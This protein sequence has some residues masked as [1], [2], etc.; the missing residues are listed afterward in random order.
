MLRRNPAGLSQGEWAEAETP[1][2][3]LIDID[4]IAG[5]VRR[6][7]KPVVAATLAGTALGIVYLFFATPL[8]SASSDILLD[9]T[10]D[11]GLT[12]QVA[13]TTNDMEADAAVMSQVQLLGSYNVAAAA[14]DTLHLDQNAEFLKSPTGIRSRIGGFLKALLKPFRG[15]PPGSEAGKDTSN[16]AR[17]KAIGIVEA[18][19]SVERVGGTY[20]IEVT[21]Q[22]PDPAMAAEIANALA[23]GYLTD[24]LNSRYQA[25][26]TASDWLQQRIQQLSHESVQ[27][28][29]AVQ[30]FRAA[31]N[32]QTANGQLITDQQIAQLNSD[33]VSAQNSTAKAKA[34]L[35]QINAILASN[36]PNALVTA[37]LDSPLIN[38][39]RQH[40][41]EAAKR[42][43]D[44]EAMVGADH[45]QVQRLKGEMAEYQ[46]QIRQELQRI[47]AGYESDYK[48]A[49]AHE[50]SAQ[51]ALDK[52]TK[53]TPASNAVL[54]KLNEL[55]I[56][57][58]SVKGLYQAFLQ[59]YQAAAQRMSLPLT[60]ARVVTPARTPTSP[61]A[62]VGWLIVAATTFL[63]GMAG[64][65]FAGL[66]EFRDRFVRTVDHLRQGAGLA[67]LGTVPLIEGEPS[68]KAQTA[69]PGTGLALDGTLL[70]HAVARPGSQ[71]AETLRSTRVA[72][73]LALAE[74]A[75][76]VIGMVS[77]LPEEGKTT[78]SANFAG[79]I[80]ASGARTLLVDTDFR[81]PMLSRTI[82]PQCRSG[83][84]EVLLK[85]SPLEAAVLREAGTGLEV[86]PISPS[87]AAF[88]SADLLGSAGFAALMEEA[89]RRYD[90][91][92]LDLPP[93]AA[94]VDARAASPEVDAFVL[95]VK[96][97]KTAR[98]FLQQTLD[99]EPR[100]A[101]KCVGAILN[102][103]D[104]KKMQLYSRPGST[105]SYLAEYSTYYRESG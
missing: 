34:K 1:E 68:G 73:D 35:D 57:A 101:E 51:Q 92:I 53:A 59:N 13:G 14:V 32:L 5:I 98:Q 29:E 82:A 55:Q 87:T 45:A 71:F 94:V 81:R 27:A 39:L 24:Q 72:V 40:Y 74:R 31:H 25:T 30:N 103:A 96:W 88:S 18:N 3:D 43:A 97:G 66:R 37:A 26:R 64:V 15:R 17:D 8:Y 54:A 23:Q 86:L 102:Q 42:E 50:K 10:P 38:D 77:L 33:L 2:Q 89:R 90:Y 76:R 56:K 19:T 95:V 63:G 100:I 22:S 62:P 69:A 28:D 11:A 70:G 20:L 46:N 80:A 48:I 93:I 49:Q 44:F 105:E 84:L 83:L 61:S 91:V 85:S 75:S 4:R 9:Q 104:L 99:A 58:D 47:A 36:D 60:G 21:Y 65:G 41:L 79:L 67:Y 78:L 16:P 52:A 7:W 12:P 6:Q